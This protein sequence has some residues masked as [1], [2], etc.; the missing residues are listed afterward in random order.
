MSKKTNLLDFSSE[1]I[2]IYEI[3]CKDLIE[4]A[5]HFNGGGHLTA[6]SFSIS[7]ENLNKYIEKFKLN[8]SED[9]LVDII[10]NIFN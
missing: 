1:N 6:S 10:N 4:I 9:K 5:K 2:N 8:L 3:N 7:N